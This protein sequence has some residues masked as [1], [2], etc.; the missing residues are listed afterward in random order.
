MLQYRRLICG[1]LVAV[2]VAGDVGRVAVAGGL[3]FFKRSKPKSC[4]E[5]AANE[6]DRLERELNQTGTVVIK[7]PDIWGES[8]LTKHRQEFEKEMEKQIGE[9]QLLL[10]ANIRRSDQAYLASALAIQA[11]AGSWWSSIHVRQ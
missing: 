7:A 2:L 6:V 4:L 8:R 10:N 1:V 11:V 5:Q 9:F 3:P